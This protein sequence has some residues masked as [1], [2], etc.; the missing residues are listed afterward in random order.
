MSQNEDRGERGLWNTRIAK[1][2]DKQECIE[3]RKK[4]E[5]RTRHERERES[6]RERARAEG[7]EERE[8]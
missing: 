8:G 5:R 6:E 1:I 3:D 2:A 4:R 7:R